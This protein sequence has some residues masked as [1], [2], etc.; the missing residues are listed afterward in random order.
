MSTR[1][2][3]KYNDPK[4]GGNPN[5]PDYHFYDE[6]LDCENVYLE[7]SDVEFNATNHGIMIQIPRSVWNEI[8]EVGKM[9]IHTPLE[10]AESIREYIKDRKV[11]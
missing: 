6:A 10:V 7:M 1:S 11:K 4:N 8:V 2:T 9:E 5:I 3:I